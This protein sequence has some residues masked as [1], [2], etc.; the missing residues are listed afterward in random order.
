MQ[1]NVARY[2]GAAPAFQPVRESSSSLFSRYAVLQSL[3]EPPRPYLLATATPLRRFSHSASSRFSRTSAGQFE[4]GT[5]QA[6][7]TATLASNAAQARLESELD[8]IVPFIEH[9]SIHRRREGVYNKIA[10]HRTDA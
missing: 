5:V 8:S 10:G 3:L 9:H 7:V 6:G 2:C 1:L 4:P